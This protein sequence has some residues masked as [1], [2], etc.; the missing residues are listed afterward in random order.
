MAIVTNIGNPNASAQAVND[1]GAEIK[2]CPKCGAMARR[3]GSGA[4]AWRC[5]GCAF[6]FE[7]SGREFVQPAETPGYPSGLIPLHDDE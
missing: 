6:Q 2:D 1:P 5:S 7:G 4:N 3:I